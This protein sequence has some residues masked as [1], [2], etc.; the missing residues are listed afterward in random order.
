MARKRMIDPE[1]FLDEELAKLSPHARLLYIGL[2]QICD[3]NYA[4]LPNRPEW[5]KA[6]IFPYEPVEASVL[7]N[8]LVLA[9]KLIIFTC[10]DDGKDYLFIKNFHKFQKID[11]PSD[12][13]YPQYQN[14]GLGDY[15]SRTRSEVKLSKDKLSKDKI[16]KFIPPTLD[17]FKAYCKERNNDVSPSKWFA[18]YESNGWKVGKNPMKDWRAAVRTWE[19]DTPKPPKIEPEKPITTEEKERRE[20]ILAEIK[21]SK[22]FTHK[23]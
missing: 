6:Q 2:W 10:E 1:F 22:V 17:E 4:T 13:K 14:R 23:I 20:K 11:R 18:H 21:K 5:I 9:N 16:S 19:S 7:I 3:D 8:E 12:P 15:S